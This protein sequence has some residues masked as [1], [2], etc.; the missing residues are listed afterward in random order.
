MWEF[1]FLAIF[2][3][4]CIVIQTNPIVNC[5]LFPI[6]PDL[7][8]P[9]IFYI[10]LFQKPV[11]GCFLVMWL[12]FLMDLFSGGVMGIFLFLRLILYCFIQALKKLFFLENK[13]LWVGVVLLLFLSDS[14]LIH[15]LFRLT[16]KDW[17]P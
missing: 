13:L 16:G 12:G 8:I 14:F 4:F 10:C 9:L 11:R 2:G 3:L 7:T 1:L 15:L 6:K 5:Y 17:G